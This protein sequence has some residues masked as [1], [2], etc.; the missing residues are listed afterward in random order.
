MVAQVSDWYTHLAEPVRVRPRA[1][2][3]LS[4][5]FRN[6]FIGPYRELLNDWHRPLAEPVRS[7]PPLG[8]PRQAFYFEG[9]NRPDFSFSIT[10][11]AD[12]AS[13]TLAV[14][15]LKNMATTSITE[16][17][18]SRANVTIEEIPWR[19]GYS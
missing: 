1:R 8:S 18:T 16:I 12:S 9:I 14:Y 2:E 6:P 10:E 11:T 17:G 3:P 13:L 7:K 15:T 19:R 4:Y 5:F